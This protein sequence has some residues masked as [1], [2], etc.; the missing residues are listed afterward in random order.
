MQQSFY[1]FKFRIFDNYIGLQSKD[2]LPEN[3]LNN[4]DYIK[5]CEK[6]LFMISFL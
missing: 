4:Q 5:F 6:G 3:L 2:S 1:I